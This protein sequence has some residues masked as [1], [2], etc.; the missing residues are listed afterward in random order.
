MQILTRLVWRDA[1]S[2]EGIAGLVTVTF[3]VGL[4]AWVPCLHGVNA[5]ISGERTAIEALR[6]AQSTYVRPV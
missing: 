4:I 1:M 3:I 5:L 6:L 2:E